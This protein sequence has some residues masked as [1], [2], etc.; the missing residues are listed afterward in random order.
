MIDPMSDEDRIYYL[1]TSLPETI[2]WK[3][4]RD[5][6]E[7]KVLTWPE[8]RDKFIRSAKLDLVSETTD[9]KTHN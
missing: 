1:L 3:A 5:T 6:F 4:W 8:M 9:E 2:S 7:D